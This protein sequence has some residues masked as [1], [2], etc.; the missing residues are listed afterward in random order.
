LPVPNRHMATLAQHRLDA[1]GNLPVP[2]CVVAR[3]SILINASGQWPDFAEA[4]L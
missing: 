3:R 1:Y 4:S 2:T